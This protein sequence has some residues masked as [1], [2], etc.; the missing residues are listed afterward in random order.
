MVR[1]HPR[2]RRT[3]GAQRVDAVVD[4][5]AQRLRVPRREQV[6]EVERG[7]QLVAAQV[8]GQLLGRLHPDLA[9]EHPVARVGVGDPAPSRGRPRAP[10]RGPSADAPRRPGR[11]SPSRPPGPASPGPWPGRARRR[12]GTRRCRGPARTAGSTRTRR[13]PRGWSSRGRAAS[14]RTGAGTTGRRTVGLGHPRP[15]RAVEVADP[16]VRR[17]LAVL[18]AALPEEVPGP[19]RAA[20]RGREGR[21]EPLV[22]VR[23]VVGDQVDDHADAQ[24]VRVRD[25]RVGVR[26]RAE[27][28]LDVAVVA[29]VVARV[30]HRRRVERADPHRVDAQ[31]A[32][33]RQ[34]GAD[35]GQVADA[36]A[37]GVGEA[38]RVDLVDHGGAP[39]GRVGGRPR[40][41]LHPVIRSRHRRAA[42]TG[43]TVSERNRLHTVSRMLGRSV[44]SGSI[45]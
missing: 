24:L 42:P 34:A 17:D 36:V 19:L 38:A 33:V 40:L 28:R 14:S 26:E 8:A 27:D 23:G 41:V 31:L 6:G 20:R 15:R 9:D 30:R 21:P 1:E 16:V 2:R 39:P 22:L 7:V 13:P 12:C 44:S 43:E 32:Q 3:D 11:R 45:G 18:A 4:R 35:P 29:D 25:Q 37:V 10:R 5:G